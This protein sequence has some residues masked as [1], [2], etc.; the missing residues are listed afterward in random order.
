MSKRPRPINDSLLLPDRPPRRQ[1]S[2]PPEPQGARGGLNGEG[3]AMHEWAEST[4]WEGERHVPSDVVWA[5]LRAMY[6]WL[7]DWDRVA[8]FGLESNGGPCPVDI[9]CRISDDE[10]ANINAEAKDAL[11]L[12]DTAA[13]GD[14]IRRAADWVPPADVII[15]DT[16]TLTWDRSTGRRIGFRVWLADGIPK[17]YAWT[18]DT[19]QGHG[20]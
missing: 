14:A 18:L 10:Y 2:D 19:R 1:P 9:V 13:V 6:P 8:S 5:A 4:T 17:T 16:C 15:Q 11:P 20:R 12:N 7:P 3:T